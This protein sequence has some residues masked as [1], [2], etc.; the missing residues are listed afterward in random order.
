M[1]GVIPIRRDT[2]DTVALCESLYAGPG[3]P[4]PL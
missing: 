4:G 3:M 2:D 1:S